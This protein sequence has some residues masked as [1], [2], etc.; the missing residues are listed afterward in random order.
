MIP[1]V[2][3]V[4]TIEIGRETG[5]EVTVEMTEILVAEDMIEMTAVA[6]EVAGEIVTSGLNG[7]KIVKFSF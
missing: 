2:V 7:R 6:E 5:A 1:E 3:V 4:A